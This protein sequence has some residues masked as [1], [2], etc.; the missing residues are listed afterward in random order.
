MDEERRLALALHDWR[1][2]T[3]WAAWPE[4]MRVRQAVEQVAEQERGDDEGPR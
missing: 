2:G 1:E 3:P 4:Q